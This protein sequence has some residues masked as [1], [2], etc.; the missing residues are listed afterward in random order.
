MKHFVLALSNTL[1]NANHFGWRTIRH[2]EMQ[3]NVCSQCPIKAL[4]QHCLYARQPLKQLVF[5]VVLIKMV[6][7]WRLKTFGLAKY[8]SRF[9]SACACT[10]LE[11]GL[12]TVSGGVSLSQSGRWKMA[13]WHLF[14]K[15]GRLVNQHSHSVTPDTHSWL[16]GHVA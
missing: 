11:M 1:C 10:V 9:V 3:F 16:T 15:V 12:L 14:N 6:M 5:S 7:I 4:K 13:S 8:M 2:Q